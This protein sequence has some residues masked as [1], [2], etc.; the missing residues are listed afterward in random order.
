MAV[1]GCRLSADPFR[2]A[3]GIFYGDAPGLRAM[4][5]AQ[6][7][8]NDRAFRELQ[9]RAFCDGVAMMRCREGVIDLIEID[10]IWQEPPK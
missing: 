8:K 2:N 10:G 1:D 3:G 5:E 7:A 9:E 4:L 6:R